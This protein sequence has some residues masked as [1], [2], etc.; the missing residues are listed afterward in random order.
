M[1]MDSHL[2]HMLH[3]GDS[4]SLIADAVFTVFVPGHLSAL[5]I[6][7]CAYRR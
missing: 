4:F 5:L 2:A 3:F 6:A 7:F 1:I